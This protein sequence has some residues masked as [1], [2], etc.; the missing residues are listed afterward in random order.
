MPKVDA[1]H[2][3][4]HPSPGEAHLPVSPG[5]ED[6]GDRISFMGVEVSKGKGGPLTPDATRFEGDVVTEWDLKLMQKL[7][8]GLEL[9]QPILLEGGSGIGK[10]STVDRRCGYLPRD[11]YYA[12]CSE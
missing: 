4:K 7:A 5:L 3:T 2:P 6:L 8:V 10:A 11:V 9:N 1:P 12:N